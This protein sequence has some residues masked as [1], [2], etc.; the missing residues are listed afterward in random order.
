MRMRKS[1]L[2]ALFLCL[3]PCLLG[4]SGCEG[5]ARVLK[6]RAYAPLSG[7]QK[8]DVYLPRA[9]GEVD[10][11]LYIHGGG[12]SAG[13]KADHAGDCKAQVRKGRA[14][15]SMNY[16][17]IRT[18]LPPDGQPASWESMLEDIGAAIAALRDT[19]LAEGYAPRKLAVGGGSAG[20]HLTLLYGC[21]RH[22]EAAIPIAFLF[23]TVGPAD[24]CDPAFLEYPDPMPRQLL[25]LFSRLAGRDITAGDVLEGSP[26]LRAMSPVAYVDAA[27]PPTLMR[28]GALD[29]I[30]PPSQ[31]ARLQA[32]LDAAGVRND[33]ILYPNSGHGLESKADA[34]RTKAFDGMFEVYCGAY[35]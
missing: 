14:A 16:R 24:L 9:K 10:V 1:S 3:W 8:M 2:P 12:W 33:L 11:V 15:A 30:V 26:L 21:A 35:F 22:A 25:D 17:M 28:Y 18:D 4:L 19:L 31:G 7:E 27:T 20:G 34:D 5:G 23:P 13:D 32:A 29:E 6:D